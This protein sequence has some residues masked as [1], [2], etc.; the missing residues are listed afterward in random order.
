LR[1]YEGPPKIKYRG[2]AA[3]AAYHISYGRP[4]M[5][6]ERYYIGM[7]VHKDSVQV[8]VFKHEGEEPIYERKLNNDTDLLIKEAKRFSQKG[9]AEAAYEAGCLGYV[10]QRAFE[11]A[12]IACYV[13]PANKVAKKRED[14][15]KTDKRDARLIGRELRSRN[16]RPIS[17]P[18]EADEAARDLLRCREDLSDDFRRA[19]QRLLKF[20]VRHGHIYSGGTKHWTVKHRQWM[21]KIQFSQEY[22]REVYEEYKSQIDS[23]KE[24]LE[25]TNHRIKEVAESPR[26]KAA[27]GRLR[28]FKG[29]DYVIAL[30][31]VCEIGDF[32]RFANAKSF[33]S[34]LGFVPSENSSGS[35][36]RQGGITKAGN[37]HIRKLLI[38]GAWHY[39]RGGQTGKRLQQR[40][41]GCPINVIDTAD[42]AL[43]RLH[44]KYIRLLMKGKHANKA[45]TAVARELAGFIWA[46]QVSA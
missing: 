3:E 6:S 24:R 4:K 11:K 21:G 15:I 31:L 42:R 33:M 30:V 2:L 46:V 23:L 27:V 14:R 40:R 20:L 32:R 29:I 10:I 26:Y 17:V 35:K 7:D 8:A 5:T 44:K 19:K 9:E 38:E 41:I 1:Q 43:H 34:Y 37:G 25:R 39:A 18:D 13:L 28:A 36:R 12:G 45:V 22:E 16:I